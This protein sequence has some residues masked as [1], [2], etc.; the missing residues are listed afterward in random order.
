MKSDQVLSEYLAQNLGSSQRGTTCLLQK[1]LC[2][3]S[4]KAELLLNR[5]NLWSIF[6]PHGFDLTLTALYHFTVAENIPFLKD[7]TYNLNFSVYK[8]TYLPKML[9]KVT[10]SEIWSRQDPFTWDLSTRIISDES[11]G[12]H[13]VETHIDCDERRTWNLLIRFG[14]GSSAYVEIS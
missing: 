10:H 7:M 1:M 2:N 8:C 4:C 11:G 5:P 14:L 3:M 13:A 6:I 12:K 9:W